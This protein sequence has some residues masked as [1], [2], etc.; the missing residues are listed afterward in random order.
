MDRSSDWLKPIHPFA[1]RLVQNIPSEKVSS[2][3]VICEGKPQFPGKYFYYKVK[4]ASS[5]PGTP[6]G[7][8]RFRAGAW[9]SRCHSS[10]GI[11]QFLVYPVLA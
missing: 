1:D 2:L 7:K 11:F 9:L 4:T 10:P 3:P 8:G 6:G 5:A